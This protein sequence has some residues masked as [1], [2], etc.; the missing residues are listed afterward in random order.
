MS[1]NILTVVYKIKGQPNFTDC[2]I[3]NLFEIWKYVRFYLSFIGP[4]N[5]LFSIAAKDGVENVLLHKKSNKISNILLHK[6]LSAPSLGRY[7][8]QPIRRPYWN[9]KQTQNNFKQCLIGRILCNWLKKLT[10]QI[11]NTT[12]W[13]L[14]M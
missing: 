7:W 4:P 5:R 11:E 12:E 13:I 2:F 6:P 14:I 8:K 1:Y 3:Y 10:V 9:S